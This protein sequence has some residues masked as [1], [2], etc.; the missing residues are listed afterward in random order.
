MDSK[1]S[2]WNSA[3]SAGMVLGGV[4]VVYLILNWLLSLVADK[5]A[6][7]GIIAMLANIIL[8]AAKFGGCIWLMKFFLLRFSEAFPEADNGDVFK[9]GMLVAL[10]SALIYSAAYLAYMLF[11]APDQIQ[12]VFDSLADNPMMNSNSLEMLE[13]MMPKMPTISFF[14]NLVYCWLFGTVL[15][16]IFSRNIPSSNPFRNNGIDEQ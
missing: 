16:A 2:F 1:K 11:L 4:C 5:S 7:T 10:F 12:E 3:A 15:S 9:Y 8:W 13:E 6:A 14:M